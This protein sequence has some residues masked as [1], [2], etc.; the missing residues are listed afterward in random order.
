MG[1][2][3]TMKPENRGKRD[4]SLQILALYLFFVVPIFVLTLIF[5]QTA[6]K[7]LE[8]DIAAADLSLARAIAL[9][10]DAML[11]KAK[12]AVV[13]FAQD[14][15]VIQADPIGME[16]AFKAGAVARQDINLFYRLSAEGIMLYH[17]PSG[18]TSTV[19]DDFSFREYFQAAL[20]THE[21][22]FSKG[23]ISPTTSRPVVTSVMPVLVNGQFDGVVATNLELQRLTETLNRIVSKYQDRLAVKI[24]IVD[25]AGQIIAH[26]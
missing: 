20:K 1:D 4:L 5:Y 12:D 3:T 14:P 8:A 23:R 24:I 15:A 9:E 2:E 16:Q 22:T 13:A 21:H 18:P 6:S 7:R 26:S 10:T 19:G 11:V 17:Y 25:A